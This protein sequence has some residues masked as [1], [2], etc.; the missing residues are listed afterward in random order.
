LRGIASSIGILPC[1]M[2]KQAD[3]QEADAHPLAKL[4]HNSEPEQSST[5]PNNWNGGDYSFKKIREGFLFK[6]GAHPEDEYLER[7]MTLWPGRIG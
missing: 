2:S 7:W 4:M 6:R 5:P 3:V 1:E